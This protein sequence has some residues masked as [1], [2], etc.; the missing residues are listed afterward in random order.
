MAP[1]LACSPGWNAIWCSHL[2]WCSISYI[3]DLA[4]LPCL[5]TS[6]PFSGFGMFVVNFTRKCENRDWRTK[7]PEG[8]F[9]G[10]FEVRFYGIILMLGAVAGAF[11]AAREAKNRD[12]E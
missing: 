7:M 6:Q 12:Q 4:S 11:L 2:H 5:Q 9:I 8:F 10:S 1:G 3:L